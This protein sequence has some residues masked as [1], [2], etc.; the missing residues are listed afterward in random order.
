VTLT[1]DGGSA[2]VKVFQDNLNVE[3]SKVDPG[4][5]PAPPGALIGDLIFRVSAGP[6]GGGSVGT[7]PSEANLGV[8]YRERVESGRDETKFSLQYWDGQKW[9]AAPKQAT[10]PG[11]NYVSATIS[12]TG[13]YALAQP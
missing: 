12:A 2:T 8:S 4:S 11:H 6:C 9:S 7:L 5:A 10:D 1:L 3:L 13:I